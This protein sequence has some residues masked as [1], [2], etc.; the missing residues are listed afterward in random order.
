VVAITTKL[1]DTNVKVEDASEQKFS[2]KNCSTLSSWFTEFQL[3]GH[4]VLISSLCPL[5]V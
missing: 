5:G 2:E 3:H 4:S 1:Q